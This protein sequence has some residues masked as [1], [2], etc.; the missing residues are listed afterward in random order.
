MV[1]TKKTTKLIIILLIMSLI[2]ANLNMA[3]LG[4]ISY[5]QDNVKTIAEE[6]LADKEEKALNIEISEITKND[7]ASGD[8]EYSETLTVKLNYVEKFNEVTIADI[9]DEI[10]KEIG[11]EETEVVK[12]HIET[13]YKTTKISK[14]ELEKVI[15][16]KGS[17]EITYKIKE[18]EE[19]LEPE[20]EKEEEKVLSKEAEK[21]GT[22]ILPEVIESQEE[23]TILT[24]EI[25]EKTI[26]T[27]D[28]TGSLFFSS[29][30]RLSSETLT[31]ILPYIRNI[32][33][34]DTESIQ[35][36]IDSLTAYDKSNTEID[37]TDEINALENAKNSIGYNLTIQIHTWKDNILSSAAK[38][39]DTITAKEENAN[40]DFSDLF[41]FDSAIGK[42]VYTQIGFNKA[43]SNAEEEL[44]KSSEEAQKNKQL[45]EDSLTDDLIKNLVLVNEA[46]NLF[47]EDGTINSATFGE[48]LTRYGLDQ[49]FFSTL[50]QDLLA[51]DPSKGIDLGPYLKSLIDKY[52]L[53]AEQAI[54][55]ENAI[56]AQKLS[57][58]AESIDFSKIGSGIISDQDKK[59]IYQAVKEAG[60]NS[61]VYVKALAGD[62]DALSQIFGESFTHERQTSVIQGRV[63]KYT[64]AIEELLSGPNTILSESTVALLKNKYEL[65]HY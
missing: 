56:V 42:W 11:Q 60:I 10:I 38:I 55:L 52:N 64:T 30:N 51:F 17:L 58:Y 35:V 47:L 41:K 39:K 34:N 9:S 26:Q 53:E 8:T 59:L 48:F 44:R 5:A 4:V 1:K 23:E 32:N 27:L 40:L 31:A 61:K 28:K 12:P 22:I 6:E 29:I 21:V 18:Q 54:Q 25:E 65:Y 20:T 14:A 50:E 13:F 63:N 43:I 7:I 57:Y 37:L 24:P 2:Y 49:K 45:Y 16:E 62:I 15:G 3:I 33:W 19:V 46:G 36:A